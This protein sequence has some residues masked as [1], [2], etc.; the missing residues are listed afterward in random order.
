MSL[1]DEA[2]YV[3]AYEI[4]RAPV[5]WTPSFVKHQLECA[6]KYGRPYIDGFVHGWEAQQRI[7]PEPAP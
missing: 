7:A 1:S 5:A 3:I 2:I 6:E 4:G